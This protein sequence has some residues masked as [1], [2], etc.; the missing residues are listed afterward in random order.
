MIIGKAGFIMPLSGVSITS[1]RKAFEA[2]LTGTKN[3]WERS[4]LEA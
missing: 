4:E 2:E 3:D 1:K